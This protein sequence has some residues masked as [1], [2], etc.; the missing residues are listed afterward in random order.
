MDSLNNS[1][2]FKGG[3]LISDIVDKSKWG[4]NSNFVITKIKDKP[5][6]NVNDVVNI[7]KMLNES[8]K[9]NID[10]DGISVLIEGFYTKDINNKKCFGI[11]L[12]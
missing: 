4:C 2:N 12:K 9:P 8:F 1:K 3:V 6:K 7:L 5:V 10:F 11:L